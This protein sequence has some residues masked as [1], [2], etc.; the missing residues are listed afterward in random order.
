VNAL[1]G[2]PISAIAIVL[3]SLLIVAVATVLV[4]GLA[5]RT[6]FKFGLRNILCRGLQSVLV[7]TGSRSPPSSPPPLS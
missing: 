3:G 1:F 5:N 2:I 4:L 6:M 7:V